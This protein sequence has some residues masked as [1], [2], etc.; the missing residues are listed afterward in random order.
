MKNKFSLSCILLATALLAGSPVLAATD[1]D[2]EIPFA[3]EHRDI[4][5]TVG[6]TR[7]ANDHMLISGGVGEEEMSYLKSIQNQY[8]LKLLITEKNGTFLS[9]IDVRIEDAKGNV[10]AD[11]T[12]EGPVLLAKI[13]A[14]K[15]TVKAKRNDEEKE[16]KISIGSKGLSAYMINF[17]DTDVRDSG[18]P[19]STP[20]K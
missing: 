1:D 7:P 19:R 3:T 8:N 17:R 14:G 6:N 10:V 2:P 13:P 4:T 11:T 5:G 18:D 15:Y 16:Q 9:D 20:L 12:T